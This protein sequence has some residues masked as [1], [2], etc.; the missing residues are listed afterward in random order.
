MF[1]YAGGVVMNDVFDAGLDAVERPDRPIPAG[2]VPL[3]SAFFFGISLLILGILF[4]VFT[5]LVSGIIASLIA[6]ASIIYDRWGK[7]YNIWGPMNMGIC[8]GLNLI[9]GLSILPLFSS[10]LAWIGI[11]PVIYIAAITSIS[12]GEVSGGN[13][14]T[15]ISAMAFCI[16]VVITIMTFG[17]INSQG[18]PT[19]IFL[20][21]FISFILPHLIKA[22]KNPSGEYIG[23]S[24]KAGVLGIILMD[25]AWSAAGAGWMAGIATALL[26]PITLVIARYFEVT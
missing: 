13:R 12:K 10:P 26:L 23:K 5:H 1:L 4:A 16:F 9:L 7:S 15:I 24:V 25:A 18:L 8:R 14:S 21:L 6:I 2:F 19:M 22:I 20:L 11:V 17:F 3:T